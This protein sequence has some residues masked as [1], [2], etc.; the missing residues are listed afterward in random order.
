MGLH[1]E[2]SSPQFIAQSGCRRIQGGGVEWA[3]A[4]RELKHIR[5]CQNFENHVFDLN[6]TLLS[7]KEE[8]QEQLELVL[9]LIMGYFIMSQTETLSWKKKARQMYQFNPRMLYRVRGGMVLSITLDDD[10]EH[11]TPD[12]KTQGVLCLCLVLTILNTC[13]LISK[14]R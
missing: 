7:I 14:A 2:I 11:D 6:V 3:Y 12:S 9:I 13:I 5:E 10:I 1:K 4:F 8:D